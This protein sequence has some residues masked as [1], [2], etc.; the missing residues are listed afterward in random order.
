MHVTSNTTALPTTL[1]VWPPDWSTL[2]PDLIVGAAT[3]AV[4]GLALYLIQ[5]SVQRRTDR[6]LARRES[7]RLVRPL[8]LIL[9]R[10]TYLENFTVL[11]ELSAMHRDASD[12]IASSTLDEWHELEATSLTDA[13]MLYRE[14]MQDLERDA[15]VL[16]QAVDRW[17]VIHNGEQDVKAWVTAHLLGAGESYLKSIPAE[18]G[19]Y[20]AL[21]EK[22][23]AVVDSRLVKRHVRLARKASRR[24]DRARAELVPILVDAVR[25]MSANRQL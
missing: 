16:R 14:R 5:L 23:R 3:G 11:G 17:F 1:A 22:G 4:I 13:L 15:R 9:Q 6:R 12:L 20:V 8:L 2:V 10:P 18:P 24:V 25:A 19:G 21:E 7:L